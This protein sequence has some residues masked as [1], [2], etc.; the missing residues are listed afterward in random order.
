MNANSTTVARPPAADPTKAVKQAQRNPADAKASGARVEYNRP[1]AED[2]PELARIC[3][4]AFG[5]LHDRHRTPRDFP[6]L[7]MA[8]MVIGLFT[9]RND[10]FGVT[11]K[12]DGRLVGSNYL[13]L[14]DEVGGIGPITIDPTIQ[15]R[16]IGRGLMQQVIEHADQR[17]MR[18]T[19]LVQEALNTTSLPLYASLGFD[20]REPLGSMRMAPAANPD[21]TIRL[22]TREDLPL[23]K[24]LGEEFYGV[25]R[26]NE[27][28]A[29]MSVELPVLV[30]ERQGK[31]RGYF[32]PGKLGHAAAE[33][34]D[35]VLALIGE[36]GRHAP[37]EAATF[38]C[39]VRQ[40][41]LFQGAL[42]A[43][44]RMEKA[45]TYMTRGPYT[46]PM[47]AWTPSYLY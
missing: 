17:G 43:G 35:D 13:S 29:W 33:T 30:R 44:H 20:V 8:N 21:N 25:S 24:K 41:E 19:R 15:G 34:A 28:A 11:A 7:E 23:L 40:S 27:L 37:P 22:A 5:Q 18:E 9:T 32:M 36:A 42:R 2:I 45:L 10:F 1:R 31:A 16:G 4:E 47:G 46:A 38:L 39:P 3:F 6:D 14:M 12:A 26:A